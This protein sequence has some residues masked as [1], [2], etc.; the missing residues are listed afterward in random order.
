MARIKDFIPTIEKRAK[1][2]M[3]DFLGKGALTRIKTKKG[4]LGGKYYGELNANS[5]A[6]GRGISIYNDGR[7]WIGYFEDGWL[8]TGNF[9]QIDKYS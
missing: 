9:I 2:S 4:T 8:S 6:H 5:E 7:I 1:I 3:N